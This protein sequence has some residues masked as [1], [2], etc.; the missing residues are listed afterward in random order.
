MEI[1]DADNDG[2][3]RTN[4]IDQINGSNVTAVWVGDSITLN[5]ATITGVTFYTADGSRYFTPNDGSVLTDGTITARTFVN[6]ST[7]FPIGDFGPPCFVTGTLIKAP[8]GHI[9]VEDLQVGDLVET[10]DSGAQEI[11]WVGRRTVTGRGAFAP[12]R[13]SAGA[14]G[15]HDALCVSPQHRILLDDWRAQVYLGEEE[16]L[17]PAHM[18]VNGDTICRVP[19]SSVTYVHFMFDRHEVV[20][21]NGLASE[22]FLLGDYLCHETSALRAEIVALFPEL[23]SDHLVMAA[24]RRTV[25][26]YEGE[27]V[28]NVITKPMVQ[29][30]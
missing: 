27:L 4:G 2:F 26:G 19:C 15:E 23:G 7:E 12:V 9:R 18:L 30:S 1:N 24:A 14:L 17:C 16:V 10:R 5:S 8:A 21:A 20:F 22:S 28:R 6:T 3:I 25:R 29:A 11:R 13:I